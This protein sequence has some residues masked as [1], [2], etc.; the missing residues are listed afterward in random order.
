MV[1]RL[2]ALH[3]SCT[4]LPR[5]IIFLLLVLISVRL[6]GSQI[7]VW[8]EGLHKLKKFIHLI[9][10][11]TRDLLAC[12]LTTTLPCALKLKCSHSFYNSINILLYICILSH[13]AISLSLSLF[14]SVFCAQAGKETAKSRHTRET[15]GRTSM[16][17]RKQQSS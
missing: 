13:I 16:T 15:K 9:G 1:A 11:Q 5:N 6:S 12:A 14:L 2:S 3:T 8:P 17:G 7:L 4:L 10:S